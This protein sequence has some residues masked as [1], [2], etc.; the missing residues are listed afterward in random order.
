VA[1]SD[2]GQG[3]IALVGFM[4]SGK[5]TVGRRLALRLAMPFVDSDVEIQRTLGLSVSEIFSTYGEETFRAAEREIIAR[6]VGERVHVLSLG[7]G[8]YDDPGTRRLLNDRVTT[9]WLD[10][11]FELILERLQGSAG[12]PLASLSSP[13]EL[14]RLWRARQRNYAKAHI[15]VRA[16]AADPDV[17]V[18][19]IVAALA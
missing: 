2:I 19:Q 7:G 1:V 18:G 14:R 10:S 11:P 3:T 5:T 9:V 15:H 12:R 6:L 8:A 17:A 13:D 4:A 16:F